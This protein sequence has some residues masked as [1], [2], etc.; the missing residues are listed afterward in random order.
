MVRV[1]S[2]VMVGSNP[3][4]NFFDSDEL[5]NMAQLMR[6]ATYSIGQVI[7]R[8]GEVG[9]DFYIIAEGSV[10]ATK[11]SEPITCTLEKH[12]YFGEKALLSG[13]VRAMTCTAASDTTCYLLNHLWFKRVMGN[14]EDIFNGKAV[15]GGVTK[16]R[17]DLSQRITKVT[18]ELK[19]LKEFNVLGEGQCFLLYLYIQSL[20][21]IEFTALMTYPLFHQCTMYKAPLVKSN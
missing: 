12:A 7:I 19:D 16:R 15:V 11:A 5:S 18:C 1:L 17:S 8:E 6:V 13:D 3:L 4:R 14:L 20:S 9:R 2:N 21:D 10:I